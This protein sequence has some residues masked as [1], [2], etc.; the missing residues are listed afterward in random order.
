[1]PLQIVFT[2][3][4]QLWTEQ[5]CQCV[6]HK[7]WQYPPLCCG[8]TVS[9]A[10][11]ASNLFQF[12]PELQAAVDEDSATYHPRSPWKLQV[13][14]Q[15]ISQW[16]PPLRSLN[17]VVSISSCRFKKNY[18]V[19]GVVPSLCDC[20][21]IWIVRVL[22]GRTLDGTKVFI[23]R[24]PRNTWSASCNFPIAC[25]SSKI[26]RAGKLHRNWT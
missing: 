9:S 25:F 19:P 2:P 18:I 4:P 21:I 13:S 24:G 7:S 1:V 5:A 10:I 8:V 11:R 26:S 12:G 20:K 22:I 17:I 6:R 3:S 14:P 15:E 16:P 23:L